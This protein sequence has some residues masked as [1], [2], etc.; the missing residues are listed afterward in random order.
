M[1]QLISLELLK[2]ALDIRGQEQ[3][4]WLTT[5]IEQA[6]SAIETHLNRS[7]ALN[8][9]SRTFD[10]GLDERVH[11]VTIPNTPI[12]Q[13][14]KILHNKDEITFTYD[15]DSRFGTV[16]TEYGHIF[17]HGRWIIEYEGGYVL[18]DNKEGKPPTLPADIQSAT[19]IIA[20]NAWF[21]RQRDTA[22]RSE[23]EQGIG[24]TTWVTPDNGLSVEAMALL[25][26]YRRGGIS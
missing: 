6:S 20:Q 25:V 1:V 8:H 23:S 7:L 19:L 12:S 5:L 21:A 14:T 18:P 26:P 16:K 4:D 3:D 24:S 2:A 13:I 11:A 10:I 17:D 15:L 9:Y 22:I